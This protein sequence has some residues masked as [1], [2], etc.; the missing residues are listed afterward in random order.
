M[1]ELYTLQDGAWQVVRLAVWIGLI[2]LCQRIDYLPVPAIVSGSAAYCLALRAY[3]YCLYLLYDCEPL[4]GLDYFF[5]LDDAKNLSNLCGVV[6]FEPFKFESMKTFLLQNTSQIHRMRSKL[7]KIN[8]LYYFQKMGQK[9]FESKKDKVVVLKTGIHTMQDLN[10]YM[11]QEIEL[12]DPL[13][14][15][16]FKFVLIPDFEP[17]RGVVILK[18]HHC[19]SDGM[20]IG[21]M[22]LAISGLYDAKALP[23]IRP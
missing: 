2:L 16:Q 5:F 8:G 11:A 15:V 9:E 13:D 1:I 21:S 14:T 22:F 12:R 6:F 10:E 4:D 17:D 20:G 19:M 7:V 23:R 18:Y 3:N